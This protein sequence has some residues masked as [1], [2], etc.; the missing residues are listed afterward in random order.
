MLQEVCC[1]AAMKETQVCELHKH[2]YD[3][4]HCGL[5]PFL[6]LRILSTMNLFQ[7]A[8]YKQ[9]N[10]HKNPVCL[11]DAVRGNIWKNGHG[12]APAQWLFM[13]KMYLAKHIV[14]A[15]EH[16]PYSPDLSSPDFFCFHN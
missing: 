7:K 5:E 9:R 14:M 3:G 10:V 1:K 4:S 2:F 12:N 11:R 6:M 15:L 8:Y 16:L 13:V